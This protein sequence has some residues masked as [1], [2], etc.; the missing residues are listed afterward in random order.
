MDLTAA[1]HRALRLRRLPAR[2]AR[3]VRGGA[4]GPRRAGRHAHGLGQVALLPAAGAAARRPDGR[5]LAARRADAGPGRGARGARA[6]RPGGARQRAAGRRAPTPRRSS[7]R[8]G[9]RAASCSTSRP[10]ASPRAASSTRCARRDV[11][12]F[13]VDEAH[14]V[15]QWGHDFRPDYFR[16]AD[17]ARTLGA[18]CDR[19]LHRHGHAA[20][21]RRRRAAARRC[22]TRC[23]WPPGFDRPNISLR[24]RAA[25]RRTRSARCSPRR[26]AATDA[27]PAIVYAGTRA[28]AEEIAGE[29]TA[30]ARRGGAWPTT[31]G[32]TASARAKV[33]RALPRRRGAR[34]RGHER[35]RDGRRQ[36]ERAHGRARQ[37]AVVARGATT[38]RPAAR[39]ATARRRGRC[40]WPR[41]ATRRCT[42]TSS[43]A[44]RSTTG[45]RA[46]SRTGSRAR[47]DGERP[48]LARRAPSSR[49]ASRGDGERLRALLGHLARAG[50]IAPSP[51]SPDRVAGR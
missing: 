12:L 35:V 22:A 11:G 34:D 51:S 5:R 20:G 40:C 4:G 41:T 50:V 38:R 49:A 28:G 47:A 33:Q 6:R 16:L 18:R 48:L 32:S 1:L 42:C 8:V 21:G 19:R 43:S 37:R 30:R 46:G 39:A 45:C 44:R 15:S 17:A 3:G 26:C 9:G 2:A 25:R 36:A 29:L 13:V 31:P 7:A 14:C 24:R 27:L 23:G 10:S